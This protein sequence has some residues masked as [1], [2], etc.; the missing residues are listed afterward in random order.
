MSILLESD[1]FES[2]QNHLNELSLRVTI[3]FLFVAGL[4]VAWSLGVDRILERLIAHLQPCQGPCMN[5]YDPA[6]WSAVRWSTALMLGYLSSLP[7]IL[8]HLH[9]FCKPG[10]LDS[11]YRFFKRWTAWTAIAT[12]LVTYAIVVKFLPAVYTYGFEQHQ[13]AG[14]VAQYNT[15]HVVMLAVYLVW[16][17]WIFTATMVLLA[18]GGKLGIITASTA[19]W[20]RLRIYGLGVLLI[21]ATLPEHAASLGLPLV[22]SYLVL[23]EVVGNRWFNLSAAVEG[24]AK[25]KFDRE[26]RRRK[27]AVVDCACLGA[28]EHHGF[29][30][31]NGCTVLRLTGLCASQN[32]QE[33]TL[34]HII[35][36]GISD[37]VITGCNGQPFPDAFVE[38]LGRLRTEYHGLDLM[39]LRS[40]RVGTPH[41]RLDNDLAMASMYADVLGGS[42]DRWLTEA[43]ERHGLIPAEL[44]Q[45]NRLLEGWNSFENT[46][47]AFVDSP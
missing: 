27:F 39:R 45:L 17:T 41:P 12:L 7:L 1:R 30:A 25:P 46:Y 11:E 37:I 5:V 35:R 10:L 18:T 26:G 24:E 14:L 2:P 13:A 19:N 8:H 42:T 20:F 22:A 21:V 34:E 36:N 6:Q 44:A 33:S 31:T 4:T 38:N 23:N 32:E 16:I 15:V 29:A 3:V 9:R 43:I 28:N 47:V 40:H